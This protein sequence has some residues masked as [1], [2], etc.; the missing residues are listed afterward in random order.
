MSRLLALERLG[1]VEYVQARRIQADLWQRRVRD[2][3]PDTLLLLEHPPTITAGQA[4]DLADL[5]VDWSELR[6][7]GIAFFF[8]DRGGCLTCHAPGQLVAYPIVDLRQ[9]GRDVL[10]YLRDLEEVVILT[11]TDLSIDCRRDERQAGVWASRGKIASIGVAVRRW[12]TTHGIAINVCS[13]L[14]YFSLI[15]PCGADQAMTSVSLE[16]GR[17]VAPWDVVDLFVKRFA[18]VFNSG[19]VEGAEDRIVPK[20]ATPVPLRAREE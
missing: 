15:R 12:V 18:E 4:A 19:R 1:R 11:L 17:D 20:A 14:N 5:L 6:R 8:A 16:L 13:D 9:R 2:E 7:Q 3:I 10:Q